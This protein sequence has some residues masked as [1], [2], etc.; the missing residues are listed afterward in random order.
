[1]SFLLIGKSLSAAI[2]ASGHSI[3]IS[4]VQVLQ[5]TPAFLFTS[6]VLVRNSRGATD[7]HFVN[8]IVY[9]YHIVDN[10]II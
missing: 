4:L 1:M 2:T 9:H 6:D 3:Q 7:N 8:I 10:V 5:I